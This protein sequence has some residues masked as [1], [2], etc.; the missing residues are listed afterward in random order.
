MTGG[1]GTADRLSASMDKFLG[2]NVGNIAHCE[3][4]YL[5]IP[6]VNYTVARAFDRDGKLLKEFTGFGNHYTNFLDA[7]RSR[8]EAD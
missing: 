3:G 4:G 2:V 8:R 5:V 1:L 7:M 6:A